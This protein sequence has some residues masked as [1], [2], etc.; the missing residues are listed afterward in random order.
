EWTTARPEL[1]A[2]VEKDSTF[3]ITRFSDSAT[4]AAALRN[5]RVALLVIPDGAQI[6]YRLGEPP[7]ET[8]AG[9]PK[10]DDALQRAAGMT[11][12]IGTS[13][14]IVR[15]KGSR[16]IDFL[17]PGLLAMNL[18]GSGIWGSGFAIVNARKNK[19]L[20]RLAATPMSRADYLAS[21]LLA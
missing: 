9:P 2:A 18:M 20:K 14:E 10:V 16:Y 1:L 17:L 7:P 21:F 11:P 8:A 6:R 4:A 12:T 19:L 5:G 13:N 15:E 3:R